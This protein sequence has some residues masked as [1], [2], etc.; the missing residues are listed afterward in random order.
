MPDSRQDI[1]WDAKIRSH[2]VNDIYIFYCS[3]PKVTPMLDF[4]LC[5][6]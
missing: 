2:S 6:L 4:I 5:F 1:D 3:I